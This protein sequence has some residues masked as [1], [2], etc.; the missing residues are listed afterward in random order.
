MMRG[1]MPRS[2][3][4][5]RRR[6]THWFSADAGAVTAEYATVLPCI[7]MVM[8]LVLALGRTS[9]VM[10]GCHDA[11][12]NVARALTVGNNEEQALSTV[13]RSSGITV[14]LARREGSIEVATTC[15]V[16]PDP[17]HVLPTWV[18]GRAVAVTS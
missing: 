18:H 4:Q 7:I 12:A 10:M 11:A 13:S 14:S 9:V 8:A 2:S 15:P 5:W 3:G 1:P 6:V 16:I 17:W